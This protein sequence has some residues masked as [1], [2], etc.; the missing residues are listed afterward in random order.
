MDHVLGVSFPFNIAD[1]NRLFNYI[2]GNNRSDH[3]WTRVVI[4]EEIFFFAP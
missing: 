3:E 2:Y 4:R 1:L